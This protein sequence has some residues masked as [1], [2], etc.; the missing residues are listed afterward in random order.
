VLGDRK[1]R[2]GHQDGH[3]PGVQS[4]VTGLRGIAA[5]GC[6]GLLAWA[7]GPA[8]GDG[9]SSDYPGSVLHVTTAAPPSSQFS[10]TIVA[11]G[12]N[13]QQYSPVDGTLLTAP[14]ELYLFQ[15]DPRVGSSCAASEEDELTLSVGGHG[16]TAISRPN[17]AESASGPFKIGVPASVPGSISPDYSG[18]L[19]IC[20][21]T[22]YGGLFD[23][24]ASASTTV[25]VT[26]ASN[27][28]PGPVGG[29]TGGGGS[30]QGTRLRPAV[31]VRPSVA[32]SGQR[33][34]CSSGSWSGRPREYRYRWIVFRRRGVAGKTRALVVTGAIRGRK[35]ECSVTATSPAGS[36]T[37][38]SRPFRVF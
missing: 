20:A 28:N 17:L 30:H 23:T 35:V 29:S 22:T 5:C 34:L 38:S 1:Q 37:A 31:I 3:Q 8:L 6:A 19:L 7:A 14:Y 33:L 32:R 16:V 21:Y 2:E 10:M 25:M 26:P 13:A 36:T 18:P 24:A 12:T 27:S 4:H 9:T 11:T 15:V